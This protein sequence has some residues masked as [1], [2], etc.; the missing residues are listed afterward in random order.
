MVRDYIIILGINI[1]SSWNM[2]VNTETNR[3]PPAEPSDNQGTSVENEDEDEKEE[4]AAAAP[5]RRRSTRR[6]N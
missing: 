4:D 1:L 3:V 2:Q 5:P 6:E